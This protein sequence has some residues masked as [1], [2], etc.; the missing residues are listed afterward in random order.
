M[1]TQ[2]TT[3]WLK[4]IVKKAA[5]ESF[6]ETPLDVLIRRCEMTLSAATQSKP[7]YEVW[8]LVKLP[9]CNYEILV[10]IRED[11]SYSRFRLWA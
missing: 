1:T 4:N 5:T 11:G 10:D 7:V 9:K 3:E 2:D 6:K 8:A